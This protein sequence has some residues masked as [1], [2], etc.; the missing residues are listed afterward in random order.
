MKGDVVNEGQEGV[1]FMC[2]RE[3]FDV[4]N[5]G[6]NEQ[7]KESRRHGA[8]LAEA[9][10]AVCTEESKTVN[11]GVGGGVEI[12]HEIND[13]GRYVVIGENFPKCVVGDGVENLIKVEVEVVNVRVQREI[14]DHGGDMIDCSV[15]R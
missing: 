9:S 8:T 2:R 13:A 12:F 4:K 6:V 15:V 11:Y 7:V 3:S 5:D 14:S 1:K 10:V